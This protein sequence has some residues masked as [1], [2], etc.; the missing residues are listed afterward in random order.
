MSD[1]L[2]TIVVHP[3]RVDQFQFH[4]DSAIKQ[5]EEAAKNRS[6]FTGDLLDEADEEIRLGNLMKQVEFRKHAKED[7]PDSEPLF[8]GPVEA[9]WDLAD[10]MMRDF[11]DDIR[12]LM[13]DKPSAKAVKVARIKLDELACWLETEE[14]LAVAKEVAA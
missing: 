10:S 12:L 2:E 8:I 7:D 1:G 13:N 14:A 11:A 9:I 4:I 3:S 6:G 5:G